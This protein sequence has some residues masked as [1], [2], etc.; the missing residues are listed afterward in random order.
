MVLYGYEAGPAWQNKAALTDPRIRGFMSKVKMLR[1]EHHYELRKKDPQSWYARVEIDARGQTFSAECDYSKGT[2]KD[3]FRIT[4]EDLD[5]RFFNN[6]QIIL[7]TEKI[8]K[9][10]DQ[11][12]HIEDFDDLQEIIQNIVL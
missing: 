2:N 1:S 7:P 5:K 8:E 12:K 3:G 6:A 4:P 9:A 11:L 10:I